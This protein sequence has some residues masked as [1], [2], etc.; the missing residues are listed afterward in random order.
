MGREYDAAGRIRGFAAA[1]SVKGKIV[2]DAGPRR[3][4]RYFLK[5]ND[6]QLYEKVATVIAQIACYKNSLPQ[7]SPCSP[8]ISDLLAHILDVRLANLAKKYGCTYSRY[9]DD[10][11]FSTSQKVFPVALATPMKKSPMK[12]EIGAELKQKI[13]NSD[14]A[15][16]DEKTRMQYAVSRQTVT[17]LAAAFLRNFKCHIFFIGRNFIEHVC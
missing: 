6:F 13:T 16:N 17:G 15:A 14:F 2:A 9:A 1:R 4:E 7:G 8:I 12:W 11:T 10:L 3:H 5:N